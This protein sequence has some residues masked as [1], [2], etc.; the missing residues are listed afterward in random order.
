MSYA[1]AIAAIALFSV[2]N[3]IA[4]SALAV[5]TEDGSSEGASLGSYEQAEAA[6]AAGDFV[7]ALPILAGI[8]AAEPDNADA[9]NLLGFSS[10]KTGDLEAAG[11]AYARA[12]EINPGHLGA[13]EY[14]GEMFLEMGKA[15]EAK[16]NLATLQGLCGSCEEAL[17]LQE[18]IAEAGV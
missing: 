11:L 8:T 2:L 14:Q 12:L 9:W 7:A 5:G 10:R 6:I 15:A 18:A 13:L 17:D 3:L 1:L 4:A 16:A